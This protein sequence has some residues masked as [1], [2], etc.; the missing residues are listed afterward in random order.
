MSRFPHL[1][2]TFILREMTELEKLGLNIFLFPLIRQNPGVVH[3][4]AQPWIEKAIFTP[5]FSLPIFLSILKAFFTVPLKFVGAFFLIIYYNFSSLNF[6]SRAILL[7]PKA[8]HIAMQAKQMEIDH[9]HVHYAT[10]PSLVAWIIKYL[11]GISY[12]VTIHA[13]DIFIRKT[14]LAEKLGQ[15]KFIVAISEYNKKYVV[16]EI[17][18]TL[19]HKIHVVH[20]GIRPEVY[21]RDSS[22][23][24]Q[25]DE[26]FQIISIGSLQ[27]YKGQK[28]LIEACSILRESDINFHCHIIGEGEMRHVLEAKIS[29]YDL[30]GHITLHGGLPQEEVAGYLVRGNCYVQPSIIAKNKKMEGIPVS[31]M[32]AMA[33]KLPV[34]A[35]RISG[36]P[37]IVIHNQTGI[38]VEEKDPKQL[39]EAILFFYQNPVKAQAMAQFASQL[40]ENEY[41]LVVNTQ[42]IYNVITSI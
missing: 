37:E 7:F 23:H 41:N 1:P 33:A 42:K 14:M 20:C 9:F 32:E 11:T 6:L 40:V 22:F 27:E 36:I 26:E 21:N 29:N 15:A 10:H 3:R 24:A 16:R 35:S 39:A 38:L 17:S 12:S 13:H 25:R 19:G 30:E 8:V 18:K 31:I 34:V 28:Y 4:E 5:Y 2:E